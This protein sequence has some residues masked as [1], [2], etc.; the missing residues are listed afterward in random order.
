MRKSNFI[1]SIFVYLTVASIAM[2]NNALS[3]TI[4]LVPDASIKGA[5]LNSNKLY[6]RTAKKMIEELEKS[7]YIVTKSTDGIKQFLPK[8]KR[9]STRDWKEV[10]IRKEVKEYML[11]TL[12][13]TRYIERSPIN[14]AQ[15]GFYINFF[16]KEIAVCLTFCI[17][18]C[19]RIIVPVPCA[20]NF[21]TLLK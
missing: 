14:Q 1:V 19:S 4:L 9:I 2:L 5:V 12:T 20:A 3:Q 15:L 13:I 21:I 17:T 7:G 16:V 11:M 8:N 18:S 10:F 6:E